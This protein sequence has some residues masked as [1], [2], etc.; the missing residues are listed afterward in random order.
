[1]L[2]FCWLEAGKSHPYHSLPVISREYPAGQNL[3]PR[4]LPFR[5]L[6]SATAL[7]SLDQESRLVWH[8]LMIFHGSWLIN[9]GI[10]RFYWNWL[11]KIEF[12]GILSL[13]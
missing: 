7:E 5:H 8:L 11:M 6:I 9:L 12:S 4:A 2:G 13:G 1:M 10:F 3:W